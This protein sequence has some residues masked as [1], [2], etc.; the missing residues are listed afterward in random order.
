MIPKKLKAFNVLIDG[1]GFAGT[2]EDVTPPELV[3]KMEEFRAGGMD[4][5]IELDMGGEKLGLSFKLA[6]FNSTIFE[7]WGNNDVSGIKMR[8]KGSQGGDDGNP[9]EPIEMILRGRWNALK[10]GEWKASEASS[11]EVEASISYY[12]L[13]IN[14]KDI[15]EI[16]VINGNPKVN[17][18]E[19]FPGR[20]KN[21]GI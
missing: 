7:K 20:S 12:K 15:V 5:P 17:G 6:D 10:L 9:E 3:R 14:G 2:A 13:I 18:K 1:V 19:M 4:T 16:D 8:L 21:L 11:L